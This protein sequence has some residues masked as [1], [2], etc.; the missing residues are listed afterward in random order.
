MI[1]INKTAATPTD[2]AAKQSELQEKMRTRCQSMANGTKPSFKPSNADYSAPIKELL[3]TLYHNKCGFCE[4]KLTTLGSDTKFTVEHYRP[5][6][7]YPWL[8]LEWTNLFPTCEGCNSPKDNDFPLLRAKD[9]SRITAYPE[10]SEG[11]IDYARCNAHS[12][13]YLAEKPLLLH[14]EIDNGEDFIVF[15]P[16]C[17]AETHPNL[18]DSYS[19]QRADIMLRIFINRQPI[20][21][22]RKKLLEDLRRDLNNCLL[23]VKEYSQAE[24][25]SSHEYKLIFASFF[26]KLKEN[27]APNAEFSAFCKQIYQNFEGFFVQ[28]LAVKGYSEDYLAFIRWIRSVF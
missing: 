27:Q 28:P 15:S 3:S 19:K 7:K 1:K 25:L 2:L 14:P 6:E 20:E 21:E 10:D 16:T 26:R 4:Q 23:T 13:A 17:E 11:Y 22:K 9:V 24:P 12:A 8:A 18:S 5:Q